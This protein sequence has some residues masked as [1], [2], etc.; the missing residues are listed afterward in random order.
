VA[1]S[2]TWL[3]QYFCGK[4]S[5]LGLKS[6]ST[7]HAGNEDIHAVEVA[8]RL[9]HVEKI[10]VFLLFFFVIAG[11]ATLAARRVSVL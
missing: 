7:Y 3:R 8:P 6:V 11:M 9:P 10:L 4:F 5:S 1:S 2:Y